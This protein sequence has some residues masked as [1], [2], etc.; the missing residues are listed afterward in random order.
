M[1]TQK[2]LSID[3]KGIAIS[4]FRV[5]PGLERSTAGILG[6]NSF[7]YK[8]FGHWD[9]IIIREFDD[10]LCTATVSPEIKA[11]DIYDILCYQWKG[12][13]NEISVLKEPKPFLGICFAKINPESQ[14]ISGIKAE[15]YFIRE[16]ITIAQR[17]NGAVNI[18]PLGT[19]GWAEVILLILADDFSHIINSVRDIRQ[20]KDPKLV[21]TS[22]ATSTL[23][24][25]GVSCIGGSVPPS[26]QFEGID[27]RLLVSCKPGKYGDVINRMSSIFNKSNLGAGAHDLLFEACKLDSFTDYV[28]QLWKAREDL[29]EH[30]YWTSTEMS[31]DLTDIEIPVPKATLAPRLDQKNRTE[32]GN[33]LIQLSE[34]NYLKLNFPTSYQRL[35][36]AIRQYNAYSSDRRIAHSFKD[37]TRFVQDMVIVL[38]DRE[39]EITIYSVEPIIDILL[40]AMQQRYE[41]TYSDIPVVG[42]ITPG[43]KGGAHR[44]FLA[45]EYICHS[46]LENW[47]A[48]EAVPIWNGFTVFGYTNDYHRYDGGAINLSIDCIFHP[49][50]W[51]GLF[52]E[53]GHEYGA[54]LKI[55]DRSD[56][57]E[58]LRTRLGYRKPEQEE[59]V[60]EIFSEI[61]AYSFGFGRHNWEVCLESTWKYLELH[62]RYKER[63]NNYFSRFLLVKLYD[64][65]SNK[66]NPFQSKESLYEKCTEI[67]AEIGKYS[68][69]ILTMDTEVFHEIVDMISEFKPILEVFHQ[70][71][72]PMEKTFAK[73]SQ[74]DYTGL[75]SGKVITKT[76]KP[77][78]INELIIRFMK[79]NNLAFRTRVA[80]ILSLWNTECVK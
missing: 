8:V 29:A 53:C 33:E 64:E 20:I 28:N 44:S 46:L 65:I 34:L 10:E 38:K 60:W 27:V 12:I 70:L 5:P 18:I 72:D 2:E 22:I 35:V 45:T 62:P 75:I 73:M 23:T 21:E 14:S 49:E 37:L 67:K 51:W 48:N 52:H 36:E 78:C 15:Q 57:Q 17:Y 69:S 13:G 50:K 58:I 1:A 76:I 66:G 74:T 26:L 71:L 31:I 25:P 77:E 11:V 19:L 3:D 9:F 55:I 7:I 80:L 61:F 4:F 16:S 42:N 68:T 54:H 79:D 39:K 43:C 47:A 6:K 32:L 24:V 56:I 41:A 59:F 30:I 40:F 63:L